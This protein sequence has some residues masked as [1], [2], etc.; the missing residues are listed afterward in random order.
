MTTVVAVSELNARLGLSPEE[1]ALIVTCDD[2]GSSHAAN[3]AIYR[4]LRTGW[5]TSTGL[6]VPAPWS[7]EAA[8]SY[9]GEDVGVHLT[10]NSEHEFLRWGPVTQSPSLLSGEGGFPR[11]V[12][13]LW[14][15]ADLDECRREC[16]AQIERAVYW[17]YDLTHLDSHL[18]ALILRPEFFDV[19]LELAVEFNL[20]VR[21]PDASAERSAGFPFRQLAADEGVLF[22]TAP[23]LAGPATWRA[24]CARPW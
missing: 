9:R 21:L 4:S 14:D 20:P 6:M 8:A 15:H 17:G 12:A 18:G 16:R 3:S 2:L 22:P 24:L 23:W 7:R 19:L 1:R 13:D 5:A 10:L 11:H